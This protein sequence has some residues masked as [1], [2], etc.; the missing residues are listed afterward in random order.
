[1][2]TAAAQA[3]M[4]TGGD[5]VHAAAATAPPR[6]AG[7]AACIPTLRTGSAGWVQLEPMGWRCSVRGGGATAS[8]CA[9]CGTFPISPDG[10][11]RPAPPMSRQM[12]RHLHAGVR[13]RECLAVP[14][15]S[16]E[17]RVGALLRPNARRGL[18]HRVRASPHHPGLVPDDT[19][20]TTCETASSE[21]GLAT[22]G[23]HHVPHVPTGGPGG[24]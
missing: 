7:R 13:R 24:R 23:H 19:R 2:R 10:T 21:H 8:E 22:H 15:G 20:T 11:P 14:G 6:L 9:T 12:C 17:E 16:A 1:M 18:Y 5:D 4:P 3:G